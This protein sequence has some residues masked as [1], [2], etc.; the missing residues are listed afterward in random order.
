M[1]KI[2]TK[3]MDQSK[4]KKLIQKI[5]NRMSAQRSR[6]RQKKIMEKLEIENKK[7][8]SVN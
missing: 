5:R 7:I 3:N 6:L 4:K 2:D 8:K 1:R